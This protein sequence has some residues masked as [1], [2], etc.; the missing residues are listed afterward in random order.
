MVDPNTR[1]PFDG[2]GGV[3]APRRHS[4]PAAEALVELRERSR[5]GVGDGEVAGQRGDEGRRAVGGKED[6]DDDVGKDP[7]GVDPHEKDRRERLVGDRRAHRLGD[8]A[9]APLPGSGGG[10][11]RPCLEVALE[12]VGDDVAAG[13][14]G[15]RRRRPGAETLGGPPG[16]VVL[17]GHLAEGADNLDG[18]E[19]S[20]PERGPAEHED[21]RPQGVTPEPSHGDPRVRTG[22]PARPRGTA[23]R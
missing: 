7:G 21:H 18:D 10:R 11:P 4:S 17:D 16:V 19:S 8:L 1:E 14:S 6:V 12:G 20:D 3:L 2:E 5:A 15:R 13:R 23:A 22:S 9:E